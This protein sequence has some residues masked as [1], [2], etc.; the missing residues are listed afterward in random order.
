MLLC[1]NKHIKEINHKRKED[2][3]VPELQLKMLYENIKIS[4]II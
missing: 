3:K 4:L 1:P 2:R